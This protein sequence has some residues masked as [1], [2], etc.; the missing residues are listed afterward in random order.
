MDQAGSEAN[1]LKSLVARA[2]FNGPNVNVENVDVRLV[3]GHIVAS[4]NFNTKTQAFDFQ[5]KAEE[6]NLARW[7]RLASRPGFPPVTGVADFTAEVSG[8][9][10]NGFLKL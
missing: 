3:A 2:T 10:S 1:R 5:G 7:P 8:N 9:L 4:G 6:F